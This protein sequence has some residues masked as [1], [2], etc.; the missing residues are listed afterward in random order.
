[1]AQVV[2]K[3]GHVAFEHDD[4]FR[5]E[6]VIRRG[7]SS[8]AVDVAA[9]RRIVAESMRVELMQQIADAKPEALLRRSP[10]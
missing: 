2:T 3:V 8:V 1:M 5:G 9:L 7:G 10:T 4:R 6:I